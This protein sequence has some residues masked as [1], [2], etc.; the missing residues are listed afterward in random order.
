[1]TYNVRGK[2]KDLNIDL[3]FE[4]LADDKLLKLLNPIL[5]RK[6]C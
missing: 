2:G 3:R 6:V 4:V 5:L 1:V